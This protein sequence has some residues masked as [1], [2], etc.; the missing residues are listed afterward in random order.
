VRVHPQSCQLSAR[1]RTPADSLAPTG[2]SAA[3]TDA[4]AFGRADDLRD[5]GRVG[6]TLVT[7]HAAARSTVMA[8]ANDRKR[9]LASRASF[10]QTVRN[11]VGVRRRRGGGNGSS[12]S[13]RRHYCH[14]WDR[15]HRLQYSI[16][17][18]TRAFGLHMCPL[19]AWR[20]TPLGG[21][22]SF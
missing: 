7:E 17:G 4:H 3:I 1:P 8:A 11:P 14:A 9:C 21:T 13:G 18:C 19:T 15:G 6:R 20:M 2:G 12:M 5:S 16:W 22:W 10:R